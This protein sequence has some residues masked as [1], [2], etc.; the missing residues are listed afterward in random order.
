VAGG[1]DI[2]IIRTLLDTYYAN[3]KGSGP[4]ENV[5]DVYYNMGLAIQSAAHEAARL[6][7]Q[8]SG[9]LTPESMKAGYESIEN[10]DANGL[11]API[12]I[13]PS[14]HGGGGK[15]RVEQWDGE[16]WVP[17][18]DWSA[19]YLDVVWDVIRESSAKFSVE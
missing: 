6:G 8:Q 2:P 14:D 16:T 10:F 9:S 3:G 7:I 4:E 13:T 1:Q 15:T 19:E 18:T 5:Y 12:T 17:L 11:M